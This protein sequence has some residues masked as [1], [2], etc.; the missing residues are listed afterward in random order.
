M[1]ESSAITYEGQPAFES[2]CKQ[3]ITEHKKDRKNYQVPASRKRPWDVAVRAA[4]Q[5]FKISRQERI[6][7]MLAQQTSTQPKAGESTITKGAIH[8]FY[9][10]VCKTSLK[11]AA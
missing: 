9:F 6:Q 3:M 10:P 2:F 11:F 1:P 5:A 8:F 7:K 4:D